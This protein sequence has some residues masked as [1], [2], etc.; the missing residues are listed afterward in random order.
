M[1]FEEKYSN[2]GFWRSANDRAAWSIKTKRAGVYD[3]HLNWALDGK[4]KANR[5]QLRIGQNEIVHEVDSTG[6]WDQY[7]SAHIGIV[8]LDEGD[9]RAIVQ[10]VSPISGFVIDFKSLNLVRKNN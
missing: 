7:E 9:Q 5:I 6:T 10:A 2:L 3:V 1:V 8:E 4:S